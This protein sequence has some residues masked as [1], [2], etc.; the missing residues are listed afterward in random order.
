MQLDLETLERLD[1]LND[2][3]D[4]GT[5]R[6]FVLDSYGVDHVVYHSPCLPGRSNLDPYLDKTYSDAWIS[7]YIEQG[8]LHVDPVVA[9][10]QRT[11]L[12]IDWSTIEMTDRKVVRLFGEAKEFGIGPHGLTIPLR[13]PSDQLWALFTVAVNTSDRAWQSQRKLLM[14][15]LI[16][17]AHYYHQRVFDIEGGAMAIATDRITPRELE[18][19]SWTA[20]GKTNQD[21]A[22]IL[23][24]S[25]ETV[26]AHLDSVRHKLGALNTT[27]AVARAFRLNLLQ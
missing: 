22:D 4:I 11:V 24:I 14:K 10:G 23:S 1:K 26:R 15:D 21:V 2:P 3:N 13:G 20:E 7:R 8:F 25:V 9:R 19:L 5:L 6:Q 17:L 27:H 18:V 16:L 12:P